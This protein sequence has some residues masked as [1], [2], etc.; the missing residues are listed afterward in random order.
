MFSGAARHQTS[1]SFIDSVMVALTAEKEEDVRTDS[2]LGEN[3]LTNMSL[4][5]CLSGSPLAVA[6]TI[7]TPPGVHV[8]KRTNK[9]FLQKQWHTFNIAL[10]M[11][12][13]SW[14]YNDN[15]FYDKIIKDSFKSSSI[16]YIWNKWRKWV[17]GFHSILNGWNSL[18][19][20]LVL[21]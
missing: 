4:F 5:V 20:C 2:T 13:N 18:K 21:K 8:I 11:N 15:I 19:E 7:A 17:P 6:V 16:R 10:V 12:I 3:F 9:H 14:M 1:S